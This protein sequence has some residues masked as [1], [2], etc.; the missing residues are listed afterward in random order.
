[1]AFTLPALLSLFT[2]LAVSSGVYFLA[3]RFHLPYT[4]MLVAVGTFVLVPLTLYVPGFR[5]IQEF[6]LT[7]ELLFY[8]F[9][10]VLIFESGYNISIRRFTEN[11]RTIS[12][13]AVVSLLISAGFIAV[14]LYYVLP[15]LGLAV[16]FILC[17]LFGALISATDPVAVLAL[18]KDVGA[19]RRLT[20]LFEGE[21]IF[22][23]G[24]AVA[25]FLVVLEVALHGYHGGLTVA[26][27][28]L[29]FLIMVSGGALFGVMLG[30]LFAKA[31]GGA[32]GN[33]FVQITLML[34]LA[35]L[36]FILTDFLSQHLELFGYRVHL[37]AIIATTLASMVLGNYGRAKVPPHAEEF[38]EKFWTQFAFFANSLVF[39]LIGLVFVRLPVSL[40]DFAV[41]ILVAIAVVAAGRAL[42]VYPVTR[43]V[44]WM[45][46]EAPI[47]RAWEHLLAWG[48]L[49][50]ALAVTMV[51][52]IPDDLAFA[53]WPYSYSPK[54]FILA[55][56][57]GCIFMTLFIKATT[58]EALM[59]RLQVGTLT[60]QE[61]I[62]FAAA[63]S[64]VRMKATARLAHFE[65]RGYIAPALAAVLR[66][67][68]EERSV[69]QS[70]RHAA[71]GSAASAEASERV[72]HMYAIGVERAMLKTLYTYGEVDEKIYRAVL[73]HITTQ[74]EAL[75]DGITTPEIGQPV[76]DVF[77]KL[78]QFVRRIFLPS[79]AA[80][81]SVD[82]YVYYR[83]HSVLAR[84]VLHELVLM[85]SQEEDGAFD[86]AAFGAV[87][88]RYERYLEGSTRKMRVLETEQHTSITRVAE[89]LVR[90]SVL[91]V[92]EGALDELYA[93]GLLTPKS[94]IALRDELEEEAERISDNE[95]R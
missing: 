35:H 34:V 2:L 92:E 43:F 81:T 38:V 40:V 46:I 4:V 27:G 6:T 62:A 15:L 56:T 94:Y 52:L 42:S 88:A 69:R 77:E 39:L 22:N 85:Q 50:G 71:H 29:T 1:M 86:A 9:L 63:R 61:K 95:P 67:E 44:T 59:Q 26:E 16:P 36:S 19:P 57:I 48:S 12:L 8:L 33:E 5:F 80:F 89:R 51:L 78:A 87:Q 83:T 55:L 73:D 37:S 49:R 47:P 79:H 64:I 54:E 72:L 70:R 30:G 17:L 28:L 7:P 76:P 68:Q 74:F 53:A 24:T 58:I 45:R 60:A 14:C 31:V 25:L 65:S 23:D 18:F 84:T 82:R 91:E 32:R 11:V 66:R 93:R 3:R 13:L 21:S 90:H 75:D 41:P 20:L 10:P